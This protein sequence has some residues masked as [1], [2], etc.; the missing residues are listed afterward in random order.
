[1]IIKI[2]LLNTIKKNEN[3]I[4]NQTQKLKLGRVKI[5]G[6]GGVFSSFEYKQ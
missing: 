4:K 6:K 5:W 3:S 2:Q 1:M